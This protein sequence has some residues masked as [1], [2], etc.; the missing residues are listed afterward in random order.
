[1]SVKRRA[2][3]RRT[4][5][6]R[7][8]ALGRNILSGEIFAADISTRPPRAPILPPGARERESRETFTLDVGGIR[9][10]AQR[11]PHAS[12]GRMPALP[13]TD[14]RRL[15][16]NRRRSLTNRTASGSERVRLTLR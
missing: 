2:P 10:T 6:L 9:F 4:T 15:R 3:R 1:M 16:Y 5:T 7:V 13:A 8:H 11:P 12:P 14:G